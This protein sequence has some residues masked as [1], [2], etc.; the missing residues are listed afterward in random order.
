MAVIAADVL[1]YGVSAARLN[2]LRIA[3]RQPEEAVD[4]HYS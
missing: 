3:R 2:G 1:R 4:K